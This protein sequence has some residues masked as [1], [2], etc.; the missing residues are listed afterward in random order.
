MPVGG[1]ACQSRHLK[2][3][4]D[5]GPS[6]AHFGNQLLKAF[7]VDGGGARLSLVAVDDDDLLERPAQTDGL[8]AQ[9]VLPLRALRV[10]Q[11]LAERGLPNVEVSVA[12]QMTG[13]HLRR[14]SRIHG[15]TSLV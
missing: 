1:V 3:Q 7:T 8:L 13:R 2:T 5:A 9:R 6:Q 15:M 11:H 4:D 14:S 12:F 10:L